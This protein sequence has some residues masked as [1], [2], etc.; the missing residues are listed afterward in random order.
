[1]S[2]FD[3]QSIRILSKSE[4]EGTGYFEFIPGKYDNQCWLDDSIY[5]DEKIFGLIESIFSK[6]V[7]NYNHSAF[8]NVH[9]KTWESILSEL[10]NIQTVVSTS[11]SVE[12]LGG[13]LGFPIDNDKALFQ[14]AFSDN[15]LALIQLLNEF[16]AWIEQTLTVQDYIAILGI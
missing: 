3:S 7:P 12:D 5:I 9:K 6:N 15:K 1:M 14:E 16:S 8:T 10:Q 13:S 11:T 2:K 4:L